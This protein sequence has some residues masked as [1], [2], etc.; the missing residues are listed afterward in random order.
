MQKTFYM[1]HK[2]W[3][4][5]QVRG[6]QEGRAGL[7]VGRLRLAEGLGTQDA[8]E[9]RET[10]PSL[11]PPDLGCKLQRSPAVIRPRPGSLGPESPKHDPR[12][13]LSWV[14]PLPD[15]HVWIQ[16]SSVLPLLPGP[17]LLQ[18]GVGLERGQGQCPTRAG[19]HPEAPLAPLPRSPPGPFLSADQ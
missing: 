9:L 6:W 7:R 4:L 1:R 14:R 8:A 5:G 3:G 13:Q 18:W 11:G 17:S 12:A 10:L 16:L 2:C 15:T 19:P